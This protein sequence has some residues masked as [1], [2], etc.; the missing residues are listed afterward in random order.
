MHPIFALWSHPR[1]MSTAVERIMRERGDLKCFHEPFIYDYYVN[2]KVRTIPH[3]EAHED[4][5]VTYE[6]IRDM[7]LQQAESSPVFFKDMSYYVVPHLLEDRT[8]NSRLVNCFLIYNPIA[9]ILSYFHLD[10]EVTCD[11]IGLEAQYQHYHGLS[12]FNQ[13]VIVE[14]EDI[15]GDAKRVIGAVWRAV[16]LPYVDH[17]FEWGDQAPEEWKQVEGWHGDVIASKKILPITPQEIEFKNEEFVKLSKKY[18]HM[19][20]YYEHHLPYYEALQL[21]ALKA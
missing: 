15:R 13:S 18:P 12:P 1:S 16:G 20:E 21:E 6:E 14:A 11:E 10:P 7:L 5:P 19:L 4:H 2:R 17:A 8:F 9:S 3:F